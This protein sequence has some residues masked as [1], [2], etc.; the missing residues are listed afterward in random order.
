MECPSCGAYN[1]EDRTQCW[2]CDE[3]LPTRPEKRQ[4]RDQTGR[5]G[6]WTWIILILLGALWFFGQCNV[7]RE[8]EPSSQLPQPPAIVQPLI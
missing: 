8:L 7:R 4:R 5:M 2:K 1:P 3:L 6:M